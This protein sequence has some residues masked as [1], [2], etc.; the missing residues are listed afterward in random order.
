MAGAQEGIWR[1]GCLDP[2]ISRKGRRSLRLLPCAQLSTQPPTRPLS[3]LPCCSDGPPRRLATLSTCLPLPPC[4]RSHLAT[5]ISPNST[6]KSWQALR[7][8]R[9][10]ANSQDTPLCPPPQIVTSS[11]SMANIMTERGPQLR[12]ECSH[13]RGRRPT[14]RL[15]VAVHT[16]SDLNSP[17]ASHYGLPPSPRPPPPPVNFPP[18]S[19]SNSP[20][21]PSQRAPRPLPRIPGSMSAAPVPPPPSLPIVYGGMPEPHPYQG[22]EERLRS[23]SIDAYVFFSFLAQVSRVLIHIREVGDGSLQPQHTMNLRPYL[24][25]DTPPHPADTAD[26]SIHLRTR[27]C[28]GGCHR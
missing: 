27:R 5:R 26:Q 15:S 19:S 1:A 21:S 22:E 4:R 7:R 25:T 18:K 3:A 28:L 11:P 14:V 9:L 10:L 24:P 6:T 20:Q 16:L 12:T 8:N 17:Q 2:G 13:R 23:N